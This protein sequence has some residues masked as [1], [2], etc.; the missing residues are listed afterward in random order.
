MAAP[1]S[2]CAHGREFKPGSH[3]PHRNLNGNAN[4]RRSRDGRELDVDLGA[5]AQDDVGS[6]V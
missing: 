1:R 4:A 6:E 2:Y 5:P 3:H